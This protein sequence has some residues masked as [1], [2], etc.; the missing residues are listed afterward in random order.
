MLWGTLLLGAALVDLP[1]EGVGAVAQRLLPAP[2]APVWAWLNA[3][4]IPLAVLVWLL[5]GALL[6]RG[7]SAQ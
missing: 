4:T 7:R 2:G 5:V 1:A 6:V 3:L